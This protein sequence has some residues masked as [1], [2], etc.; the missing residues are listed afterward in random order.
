MTRLVYNGVLVLVLTVQYA[1]GM[2]LDLIH[3]SARFGLAGDWFLVTLFV[4]GVALSRLFAMPMESA[5]VRRRRVGWVV[6]A[7]LSALVLSLLLTSG[8]LA[9][10]RFVF[11]TLDFFLP[12]RLPDMVN[13]W[14]TAD[15][16]DGYLMRALTSLASFQ[17]L[18]VV[19]LLAVFTMF[20]WPSRDTRAARRER[21]RSDAGPD[22]AD[23][24][25]PR[26]ARQGLTATYVGMF[27]GLASLIQGYR[28]EW[29]PMLLAVVVGVM[30]VAVLL[31]FG[32]SDARA[33]VVAR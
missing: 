12:G 31:Y 15:D 17:F 8:S 23:D 14:S 30:G 11:G 16:P 2:R 33:L 28:A 1:I 32:R 4:L 18:L 20:V 26:V 29:L 24:R 27:T 9:L 10:F 7:H 6:G 19:V 21:R 22:S 3:G 5:L 13:L 25:K